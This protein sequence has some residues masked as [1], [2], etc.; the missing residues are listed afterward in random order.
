M[1]GCS[2]ITGTI[3][4]GFCGRDGGRICSVTLLNLVFSLLKGKH[5]HLASS[6]GSNLFT[7]LKASPVTRLRYLQGERQQAVADMAARFQAIFNEHSQAVITTSGESAI[8]AESLIDVVKSLSDTYGVEIMDSTELA[9]LNRIVKDAPGLQR[10]RPWE[11]DDPT[12]RLYSQHE[13]DSRH[14]PTSE[15]DRGERHA[16][17]DTYYDACVHWKRQASDLRRQLSDA[18]ATADTTI[19]EYEC[20]VEK[21]SSKIDEL[22]TELNTTK[23]Q[24][25]ELRSR[26]KRNMAQISDLEGEVGRLLHSLD[27]VRASNASVRKLYQE[28][29]HISGKYRDELLRQDQVIS[30][31]NEASADTVVPNDGIPSPP[32]LSLQA[33]LA[34]VQVHLDE[35]TQQNLT[36]EETIDRMQFEM[37]HA[38]ASAAGL[39]DDVSRNTT[40][41][42]NRVLCADTIVVKDNEDELVLQTT[43]S[44]RKGPVGL[45]A[46]V[47]MRSVS[48]ADDG[49]PEP[50]VV[51]AEQDSSFEEASS[52]NR[53]AVPIDPYS[54]LNGAVIIEK[55]KTKKKTCF[56]LR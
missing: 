32:S 39:S 27:Q 23:R 44:K 38:T 47:G 20:K 26:E 19:V 1:E 34:L 37:T 13:Q 7:L 24:E 5:L 54:G 31:L 12:R 43:I 4:L 6:C 22:Q 49:K 53:V 11:S 9:Q 17:D 18:E 50:D 42:R 55:G 51:W 29:C 52:K 15:P 56:F 16:L 30:A 40:A 2:K 8:P 41:A 25:T 28:Q 35:Q 10:V 45:S 46:S 33:E 14:E 48:T 3:E 36:L 21:L